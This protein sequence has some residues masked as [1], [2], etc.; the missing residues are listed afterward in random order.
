VPARSSVGLS[1][2]SWK[3]GKRAESVGMLTSATG[4]VML[5]IVCSA[6]V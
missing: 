4:L 1:S 6:A 5:D 2:P 3:L